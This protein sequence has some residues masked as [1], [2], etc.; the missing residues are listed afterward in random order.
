M[1]QVLNA[2]PTFGSQF[3]KAFQPAFQSGLSRFLENEADIE[4]EQRKN[5]FNIQAEE[6]KASAQQKADQELFQTLGILPLNGQNPENAD[7]QNRLLGQEETGQ[8]EQPERS[9][10]N[11]A[12]LS[13][14]QILGA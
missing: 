13:Q 2:K 6:R 9:P 5:E 12:N 3:N 7:V 14:Q 8:Q 10:F 1:V 11:A 4:K